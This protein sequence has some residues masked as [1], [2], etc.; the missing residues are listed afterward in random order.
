M[1]R[2]PPLNSFSEKLSRKLDRLYSSQKLEAIARSTGFVQRRSKFKPQMFLD[3][4]LQQDFE[5]SG[6]SLNDHSVV[7][8]MNYGVQIRKQSLHERFS[9]EAVAFVKAVL[10]AHLSR[11]INPHV[12]TETLRRFT[13][14]K[15]KDSTR[16]Q[17]PAAYKEAYPANGGNASEAGLHLQ[18]EFDLLGGK[19]T[20]LQI[21]DALQQDNSNAKSTANRVEKGSLLIRDLG[22]FS[23]DAFG[24]IAARG[25]Y[26]ISRLRPNIKLYCTHTSKPLDLAGI[27]RRMKRFGLPQ[28]EVEVCLGDTYKVPV[29]LFA[30]RVSKTVIE[31][32]VREARAAARR[33]GRTLTS[34]YKEYAALNLFV[35]NV[36]KAWLLAGH[37]RTLYRLRWQ[38]EL[39]FKVWKSLCHL[40]EVKLVN[41]YRFEAYLY[42]KLLAIVVHWE[43]AVNVSAQVWQC[44]GKII[45]MYK[46]YKSVVKQCGVLRQ[47]L[48]GNKSSLKFYIHALCKVGC[49]NLLTEKRKARVSQ[50]EI[51]CLNLEEENKKENKKS[52]EK[53]CTNQHA[54]HA[55]SY[56]SLA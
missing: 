24:Q 1:Q 11:Q 38:I 27:S 19:I 18:F 21:T 5:H 29:R 17:L 49:Q 15:I 41:R 46:Y 47:I 13:S 6:T 32:R 40:H 23:L 42:A 28:M 37:V 8:Q 20:D 25:G 43:I 54:A 52:H 3:M 30:E 48:F 34:K 55:A 45:S 44:C 50:A 33:K 22:Y 16:F 39:R 12:N 14:V 2:L 51:L 31:K 9:A 53:S 4:L 36:P 35:S 7:T 26:F 10:E 56:R